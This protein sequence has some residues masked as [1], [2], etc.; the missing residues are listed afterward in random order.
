MERCLQKRRREAIQR[1]PGHSSA[2]GRHVFSRMRSPGRPLPLLLKL[3]LPKGRG[4]RRHARAAARTAS[5]LTRNLAC[6]C[7]WARRPGAERRDA[8]PRDEERARL[9]TRRA[10]LRTARIGPRRACPVQSCDGAG[11][12]VSLG[13]GG[14][15]CALTSRAHRPTS[16]ADRAEGR[17]PNT[18]QQAQTVSARS[19]AAAPNRQAG[20]CDSLRP[21]AGR[22]TRMRTCGARASV[23]S[24]SSGPSSCSSRAHGPAYAARRGATDVANGQLPRCQ[25][26]AYVTSAA[27]A[28]ARA[29]AYC[30]RPCGCHHAPPTRARGGGIGRDCRGE[31]AT[32][33]GPVLVRR[34]RPRSPLR[35]E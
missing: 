23:A 4:L 31:R 3:L 1:Q 12:S 17:H 27:H 22:A 18:Q 9:H 14:R 2:S 25:A 5:G 26:H 11:T 30:C 19:R 24:P 21:T 33:R 34:G 13:H 29:R 32:V 28:R 10:D 6:S 15:A 16:S 8:A 20:P 7:S 35:S